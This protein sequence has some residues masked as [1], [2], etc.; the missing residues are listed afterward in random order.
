[1][2]NNYQ[3]IELTAEAEDK[4]WQ[5]RYDFGMKYKKPSDTGYTN[6]AEYKQKVS[7]RLQKDKNYRNC[8]IVNDNAYSASFTSLLR[9]E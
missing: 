3:I 4:Y 5:L 9:G 2:E 8:L 7:D 1:M 6:M